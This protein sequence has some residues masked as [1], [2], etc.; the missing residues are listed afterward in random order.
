MKRGRHVRRNGASMTGQFAGW[1][2]SAISR[3]EAE[4]QLDR[5]AERA[6]DLYTNDAMAHGV[7]ESLLVEAVGIGHTPQPAPRPWLDLSEDQ[8]EEFTAAAIQ[9]WEQW[10]CD[11]RRWCDA[12]KRLDYYGLQGL[13]YFTWKLM[14]IGVFQVVAKSRPLSP[15]HD[16][17]ADLSL[18]SCYS[19]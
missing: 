15:F 14:G 18:P 17:A 4:R 11:C 19:L 3:R 12:T 1:P 16:L 10:G 9:I 2:S 13:G 7:L 5:S 6:Q 8:F